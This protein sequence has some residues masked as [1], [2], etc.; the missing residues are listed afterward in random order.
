MTRYSKEQLWKSAYVKY[1]I[2]YHK[3]YLHHPSA[4]PLCIDPPLPCIHSRINLSI[5]NDHAHSTD[6]AHAMRSRLEIGSIDRF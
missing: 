4:M 5:G 1:S 6:A 2:R 3:Q